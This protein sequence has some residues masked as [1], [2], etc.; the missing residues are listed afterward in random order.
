V[1]VIG[2]ALW[3]LEVQHHL[4]L[5]V[6]SDYHSPG[7]YLALPEESSEFARD[8]EK[9]F[10]H[11]RFYDFLRRLDCTN[12]TTYRESTDAGWAF[13]VKHPQLTPVAWLDYLCGWV[14]FAQ[15]Y[16]PIPNPHCN[17]WK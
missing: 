4:C 2:K 12:A 15:P 11:L 6:T 8:S 16:R 13:T 7:N 14:A 5:R 9:Q 3:A 17:E 1:R 10:G